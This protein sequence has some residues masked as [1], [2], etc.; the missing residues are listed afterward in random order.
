M[1]CLIIL[2]GGEGRV[3]F[4]CLCCVGKAELVALLSLL[5]VGKA[6]LVVFFFVSY[7]TSGSKWETKGLRPS[8]RVEHFN[9]F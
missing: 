8:C 9:Q 6:Q 2:V 1:G 3:V 4:S 5:C 7:E